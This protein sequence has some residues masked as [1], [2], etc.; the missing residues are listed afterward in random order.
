MLTTVAEDPATVTTVQVEVVIKTRT[1]I[2]PECDATNYTS[3]NILMSTRRHIQ[4][5][6]GY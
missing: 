3:I 4:A 2:S 6:I 5:K 1:I